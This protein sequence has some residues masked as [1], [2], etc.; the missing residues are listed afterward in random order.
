MG[1]DPREAGNLG[2]KKAGYGNTYRGINTG[3]KDG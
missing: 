2:T 3:A 1:W